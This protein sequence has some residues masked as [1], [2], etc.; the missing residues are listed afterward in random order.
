[1]I[2]SMP[3]SIGR[4]VLRI[5]KLRLNFSCQTEQITRQFFMLVVSALVAAMLFSKTDKVGI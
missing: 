5:I 2:H 1:M 4:K 3:F